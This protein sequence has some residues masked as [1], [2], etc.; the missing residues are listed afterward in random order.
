MTFLEIKR[1]RVFPLDFFR[2]NLHR[3]LPTLGVIL[4]ES[5][6][7]WFLLRK[8]YFPKRQKVQPKMRCL[9][10]Q[11]KVTSQL[12]AGFVSSRPSLT[13]CYLQE[14]IPLN[15]QGFFVIGQWSAEYTKWEMSD[16]HTDFCRNVLAGF[17]H[18]N[19][20]RYFPI[21]KKLFNKYDWGIASCN[22]CK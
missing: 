10:I 4:C 3:R 8:I 19:L 7:F 13:A 15:Y 20:N 9:D 21:C 11:T 12:T 14:D 2:Q 18:H 5:D 6:D 16:N 17:L 1:F 22:A